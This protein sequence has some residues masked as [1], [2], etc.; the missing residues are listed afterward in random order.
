MGRLAFFSGLMWD[1][2]PS[3]PGAIVIGVSMPNPFIERAHIKR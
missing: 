2:K 1:L 3:L